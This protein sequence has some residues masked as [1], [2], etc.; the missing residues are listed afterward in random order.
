MLEYYFSKK[1]G[2][3]LIEQAKNPK[4]SLS[5]PSVS[6]YDLSEAKAIVL[7]REE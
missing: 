4:D 2:R 7:S 6:L 5:K 1:G 3:L